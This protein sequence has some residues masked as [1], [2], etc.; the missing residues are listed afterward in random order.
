MKLGDRVSGLV[1]TLAEGA[2]SLHG[3]VKLSDGQ[4]LPPRLSVFLVPAESDNA[5]NVLRFFASMVLTDGSFA[6]N[7]LP[8][9]RYWV[10]A[11]TAADNEFDPQLSS[12]P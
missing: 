5:D 9:G 8:P 10:S 11:R 12:S 6:L 2:A 7:N 3:Q 1:L 4:K